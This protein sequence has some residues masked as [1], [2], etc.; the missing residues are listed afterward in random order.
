[1]VHRVVRRLQN[2]SAV[3][4][5]AIV[6]DGD[7]APSH[8]NFEPQLPA[9]V[10][11]EFDY[12]R[13]SHLERRRAQNSVRVFGDDDGAILPLEIHRALP[14]DKRD[15]KALSVE[16]ES[17]THFPFLKLEAEAGFEPA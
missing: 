3:L 10:V 15:G 2:V 17:V 7:V 4:A 11:P 8:R 13:Q 14:G 16:N 9:D 5:G 6:S 12:T 1:M